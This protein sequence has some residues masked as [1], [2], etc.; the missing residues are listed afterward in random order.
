MI[1][2]VP[3]A[4]IES[5]AELFP[6]PQAAMVVA[7]IAAGN[8]AAQLWEAA[9]RA[10]AAV[11]LWDKGNNV[12]YLAG[13]PIGQATRRELAGLIAAHTRPLALAE[14]R[15]YFKARALA[16]SN[17][18]ALAE[19]FGGVALREAHT[20]FYSLTSAQGDAPPAPALE[21]AR[22]EPIDRAL[23]VGV[24]E[25]LAPV[26]AEIQAMWPSEQ[27]FYSH[28]FG[29]AAIVA[30]RL[31]CWCTAE[32]V[33]ADRCGIGIATEPAYERRGVATA[34][35]ARFVQLARQR[36]VAPHWECGSWNAASI[37]VAEKIGFERVAE[38]RVWIGKFDAAGGSPP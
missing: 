26:R 7:S 10:S 1:V 16:P 34:T 12:F 36:G 24:L 18:S 30:E 19:I 25:N 2:E 37:R 22:F 21:G 27:R 8:S 32:Y 6:G 4:N 9:Q 35:A 14:G 33:S 5:Y 29:C 28:G 38:E 13:A 3:P 23:L 17:E 20:L 15:P 31:I 11:L